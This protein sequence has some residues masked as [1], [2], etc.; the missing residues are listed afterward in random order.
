[1]AKE[2]IRGGERG[3]AL[4]RQLLAFSRKQILQPR[5]IDLNSIILNIENMLERLIPENIKLDTRLAAAIGRVKADPGQI[6][7]VMVNLVINARDAMPG[8]GTLAIETA[9]VELDDEYAPHHLVSQRGQY[10]MVSVSDTGVGMD[11]E[12]LSHVFEPFFTTKDQGGSGL[13]L[14]TVY[15]IVNQSGGT[16]RLY[17]EVGHGTTFKVFLPRVDE[18]A[19]SLPAEP[20]AERIATGAETVLLVEDNAQVREL[21]A[22]ILRARG[23]K[24]LQAAGG[25]EALRI[26]RQPGQNR[27]DLLVTDVIM[28]HMSG[29]EL[30]EQLA[31]AGWQT[32]VLY[33][34]GY[35][36]NWI[37][38][39]G[40]LNGPTSF[41]QKPFTPSLLAAKVREALDS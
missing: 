12:T 23:Y 13:G 6:E 30:A 15:G 29:P 5:V 28:P 3:A 21:A 25:E 7:Q 18:P 34:S 41:L 32:K 27:I 38:H 9:A 19:D 40:V 26:V 14:A 2:I 1:M 35:T 11:Q 36:D 10:V 16:V 24:V 20:Q 39:H 31:R 33:I 8:G 4:A 37:V 22:E 17:S